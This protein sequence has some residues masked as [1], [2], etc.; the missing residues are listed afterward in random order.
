MADVLSRVFLFFSFNKKYVYSLLIFDI[1]RHKI[2]PTV[3]VHL[4]S[5]FKVTI[6]YSNQVK[7]VAPLGVL[8]DPTQF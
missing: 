2:K 5:G 6:S 4:Q 3:A 8:S 7:F 1:D